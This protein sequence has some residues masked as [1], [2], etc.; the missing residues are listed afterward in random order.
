MFELLR[1]AAEDSREPFT[2][3]LNSIGDISTQARIRVR[4]R[5]LEAGLFGDCE[6]V[7]EGVLELRDHQGAGWR[8]YFGRHG[9]SIVILLM[10][11][12]KRTQANDIKMAKRYWSDWKRRQA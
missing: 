7:G 9:R 5:R 3:W 11:G 1:Y 8:V 6:S 10:G 12:T 4:L 2:E